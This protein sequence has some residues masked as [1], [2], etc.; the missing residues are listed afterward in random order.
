MP[1]VLIALLCRTRRPFLLAW[2]WAVLYYITLGLPLLYLLDLQTG[3]VWLSWL[4]LVLLAG[5]TALLAGVFGW[6]VVRWILPLRRHRRAWWLVPFGV[7][8]VWTLTQWA[9]GLGD[10]AFVW[11]HFASAL[12]FHPLLIQIIDTLGTWGLEFLIVFWGCWVALAFSPLPVGEGLGVRADEPLTHPSPPSPEASGEV[13]SQTPLS[14]SVG[15]GLGGRAKEVHGRDARA[16]NEE[17]Q[18]VRVI[19]LLVAG[20]LLALWFGVGA[21]L[22][23]VWSMPPAETVRVAIVQP[24]VDLARSYAPEEWE[25]VRA[26]LADLI[27]QAGTQQPDLI[28]FPEVMEP[29]PMPDSPRAF[30]W[31]R[32]QV[33]QVGIPILTGGYRIAD[34]ENDLW[35]NAQH[36]FLPDGTWHYHDKVQLVPLGERV[37][38]RE[39]LGFL[40]VF[41]VV[42]RDMLPG[43]ELRPLEVGSIRVGTVICM[44]SS[45]PWV[46]RGMVREGANLLV[47]GSNESWFGRTPALQQH[48]AFSIMRAVESRRWVVRSAPEGISAFIS[49]NGE[50]QELTPFTPMVEVAPVGLLESQTLAVRLGDWA[51]WV[52]AF[53]AAGCWVLKRGK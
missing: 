30:A 22:K 4:G 39:F 32:A 28:V 49:P 9:R 5:L 8:G 43:K 25:T 10:F 3:S 44:E 35:T 50:V 52:C 47:V 15:E 45:Y 1:A 7:A 23:S 33:Q 27:Q 19:S 13:G 46:A 36:L 42:E 38:Y 17:G 14:H 24:N 48:L 20:I 29:Y 11:G 37:P 6:V 53:F 16:T 12:A 41:G 21:Y 2:G 51:I 34:R 40:R 26:R 18:G 31:W